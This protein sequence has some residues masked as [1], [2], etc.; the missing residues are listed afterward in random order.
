M[1]RL[2]GYLNGMRA[3]ESSQYTYGQAQAT[4]KN[5]LFR[6]RKWDT[7]CTQILTQTS[8][9]GNMTFYLAGNA[10]SNPE[11]QTLIIGP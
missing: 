4:A 9:R 5:F 7:Y 8:T 1:T 2:Y 3:A 10:P 6:C 11:K